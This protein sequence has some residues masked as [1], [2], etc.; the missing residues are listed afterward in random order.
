MEWPPLLTQALHEL[1]GKIGR[2]VAHGEAE[3]GAVE[4]LPDADLHGLT[5]F[6]AGFRSDKGQ[7]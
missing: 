7:Q 5:R 1:A 3:Q 2:G 4:T 6:F